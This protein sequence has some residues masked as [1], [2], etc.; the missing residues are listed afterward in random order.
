[1]RCSWF[2]DT[3]DP[4]PIVLQLDLRLGP[5]DSLHVY[6]GLVQRAERLLQV[7][8]WNYAVTFCNW[9]VAWVPA[10]YATFRGFVLTLRFSV[11]PGSYLQGRRD[12]HTNHPGLLIGLW[13]GTGQIHQCVL[14]G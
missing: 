14:A 4:K 9:L 1:M 7:R 12:I 8:L 3:Q 5:G 2:L 11:W 10:C 13:C 6:D